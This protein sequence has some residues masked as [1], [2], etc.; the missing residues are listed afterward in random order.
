MSSVPA[1]Q[2][3]G[4]PGTGPAGPPPIDRLAWRVFAP[5]DAVI[6][7]A[8]NAPI[9]W[10]LFSGRDEIPLTG[11]YGLTMMALPMT[12]ILTTAT[13]F[14]GIWNAVRERRAGRAAPPLGADAPWLVRACGE[15]VAAGLVAWLLAIAGAWLL[16]RVAPELRVGP[17]G[18]VLAIAAYAGLL[19]F[20]AHGRAVVRGGRFGG[21]GA[22]IAGFRSRP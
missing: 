15:A 16:G 5:L 8:I 22:S 2:G 7:V 3:A 12:F 19:A 18:A 1:K 6:N 11:P 17:V 20:L 4:T 13:S 14:F 9:A 21:N 10:W